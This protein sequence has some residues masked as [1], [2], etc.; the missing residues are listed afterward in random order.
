LTRRMCR[1]RVSPV[2]QQRNRWHSVA[3]QATLSSSKYAIPSS[4]NRERHAARYLRPFYPFYVV[5]ANHPSPHSHGHQQQSFCKIAVFI[6]NFRLY[7]LQQRRHEQ[8]RFLFGRI[9]A[10]ERVIAARRCCAGMQ[11]RRLCCG[12]WRV[13]VQFYHSCKADSE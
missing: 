13:E 9:K 2:M 10:E 11:P 3:T 8:E 12:R 1:I 5:R 7:F 4:S 6:A